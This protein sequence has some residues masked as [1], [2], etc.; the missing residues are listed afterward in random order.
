MH[1][2]WSP[3]HR[4]G[5]R[6]KLHYTDTGNGHLPRTPPTDTTNGRAHN[7]T[8]CCTTNS[9]STDK[10]LLHPN[11]LTLSRCCELVR[12]CCPLVVLYNVSVADVRV[13]EFGHYRIAPG[14]QLNIIPFNI[15]RWSYLCSF[16]AVGLKYICCILAISLTQSQPVQ[17]VV[18]TEKV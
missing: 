14:V 17:T 10:N 4:S 2:R 5:I 8:T 7:S 15:I 13:V 16:V 9:P 1:V 12:W 3:I 11:I 6:L 18:K